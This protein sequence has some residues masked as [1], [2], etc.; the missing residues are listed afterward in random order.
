MS[1]TTKIVKLTP[2]KLLTYT[3]CPRRMRLDIDAQAALEKS[4]EGL[5]PLLSERRMINRRICEKALLSQG[6]DITPSQT[7]STEF[8]AAKVDFSE[9]T[10]DTVRLYHVTLSTYSGEETYF[11]K[12]GDPPA[13][14]VRF[15]AGRSVCPGRFFRISDLSLTFSSSIFPEESRL[16]IM[17]NSLAIGCNLIPSHSTGIFNADLAKLPIVF[18]IVIL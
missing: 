17:N 16:A 13:K 8:Y 2:S 12:A 9:I 10:S 14:P 1:P 7:F 3:K 6:R 4:K 11:T 5:V 15:Y 18:D